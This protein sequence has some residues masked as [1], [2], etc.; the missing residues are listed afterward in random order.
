MRFFGKEF[1]TN[2]PPQSERL[3][4]TFVV[5]LRVNGFTAAVQQPP[6]PC[7]PRWS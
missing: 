1:K 3:V 4:D 6:K 5:A 2:E 7:Q